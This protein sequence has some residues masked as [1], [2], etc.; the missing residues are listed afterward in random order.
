MNCPLNVSICNKSNFNKI[1]SFIQFIRRDPEVVGN[2]RLYE[3][4]T[5]QIITLNSPVLFSHS[6]MEARW[7]TFTSKSASPE[8]SPCWMLPPAN[9]FG[10]HWVNT[11]LL[12]FVLES[13][14]VCTQL[15]ITFTDVSFLPQL[16]RTALKA[17]TGTRGTKSCT[18]KISC[19]FKKKIILGCNFSCFCFNDT[20]AGWFKCIRIAVNAKMTILDWITV[21]HVVCMWC[22]VLQLCSCNC[23]Y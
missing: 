6:W 10:L 9:L 8:S 23:R 15:G 3:P 1:W 18:M 12:L 7:E 5:K 16:C 20:L 2:A 11:A 21:V 4:Y 17:P 22:C 13:L 19:D 14:C